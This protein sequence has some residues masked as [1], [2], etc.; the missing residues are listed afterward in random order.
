MT[1][2]IY[3][4]ISLSPLYDKNKIISVNKRMEEI[5]GKHTEPVIVDLYMYQKVCNVWHEILSKRMNDILSRWTRGGLRYYFNRTVDL[6]RSICFGVYYN[7]KLQRTYRFQGGSN[8]MQPIRRHR[9]NPETRASQFLKEY[10]LYDKHGYALVIAATMPYAVQQEAGNGYAV[11]EWVMNDLLKDV[12]KFNGD[13]A[14]SSERG[15]LASPKY[16]YIFES[17]GSR[18]V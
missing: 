7:N 15:S 16:G 12:Y 11:L 10:K 14:I 3:C 9:E 6:T 2:G 18:G 13:K 8:E 17:T 5:I 1:G 4:E